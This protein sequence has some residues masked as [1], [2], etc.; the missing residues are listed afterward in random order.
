MLSDRNFEVTKIVLWIFTFIALALW[1]QPGG[2]FGASLP[3]PP[4]LTYVYPGQ[5]GPTVVM[6]SSGGPIYVWP[7]QRGGAAVAMPTTPV[8]TPS[9]APSPSYYPYPG[10]PASPYTPYE[11]YMSPSPSFEMPGDAW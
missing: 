5:N 6:P 9:P 7:G 8:Y 3:P 4:G 1:I 2:V 11:S 10:E